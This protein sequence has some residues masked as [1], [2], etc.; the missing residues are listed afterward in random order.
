MVVCGYGTGDLNLAILQG[1]MASDDI[2]DLILKLP[3]NHSAVTNTS[4]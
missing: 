2:A 4:F 3:L 1:V